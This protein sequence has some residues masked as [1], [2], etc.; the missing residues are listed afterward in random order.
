MGFRRT[1]P[2]TGRIL[3]VTSEI[4]EIAHRN[5]TNTF[6]MSP[7]PEN[8]HCFYGTCRQYCNIQHPICAKGDLIEVI[9]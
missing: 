2:V 5:L 6:F 1:M 9:Y 3:N 7:E 8:N 4:Y